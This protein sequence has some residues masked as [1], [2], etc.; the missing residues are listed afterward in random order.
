VVVSWKLGYK[1]SD[2]IKCGNFF[3]FLQ[4][5]TRLSDSAPRSFWGNFL[6]FRSVSCYRFIVHHTINNRFTAS[7]G[8]I[9]TLFTI[10]GNILKVSMKDRNKNY[11][12]SFYVSYPFSIAASVV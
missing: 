5:F 8:E 10:F 11:W 2:L 1:Y 12:F 6:N 9:N 7:Y 3:D 4:K